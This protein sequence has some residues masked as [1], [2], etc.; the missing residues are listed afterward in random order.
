MMRRYFRVLVS[1]LIAVTAFVLAVATSKSWATEWST[2]D[3][4]RTATISTEAG[5]SYESD[6][7]LR[8]PAHYREWIYLSSG[9]DMAYSKV[10]LSMHSTFDN[11]FVEPTAY[12]EFLRSGTWPDG[13]LLVLESRAASGRGSI[14][15]RGKYQSGEPLGVE[16]HV[17]DSKRFKGDWA[18]FSFESAK[19]ATLIPMTEDCY[20]CH[21]EHGAVD[22][23]FVQFYPTL[24][25]VAT[26][27]RTLSPAYKP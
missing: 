26:L 16:V 11:V 8:Y 22:T 10:A 1:V 25:P 2:D 27:K 13:T 23:T 3:A 6:G 9:I 17:R 24:L 21:Q 18:F 5:P 15:Q 4:Q 12:R 14:N 19:P 20:S 7:R